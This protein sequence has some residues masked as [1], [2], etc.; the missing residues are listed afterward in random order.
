MDLSRYLREF[1]LG[2]LTRLQTGLSSERCVSCAGLC[3]SLKAFVLARLFLERKRSVLVVCREGAE[4]ERLQGELAT[5]LSEDE[6][7][8]F[9]ELDTLPFEKAPPHPRIVENRLHTY[10]VLS[11]GRPALLVTTFHALLMRLVPPG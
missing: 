9:P 4:S 10:D 2:A 6:A 3:G 7:L 5:L 1:D 11:E 8:F